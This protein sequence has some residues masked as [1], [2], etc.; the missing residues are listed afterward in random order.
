LI[1]FNH[2]GFIFSKVAKNIYPEEIQYELKELLKNK[3]NLNILD[4]GAGTGALSDFVFKMN[5]DSNFVCVDPAFGMLK[6]A[7][8]YAFKVV[9]K[10]EDLPIKNETIDLILIGE[11]IHHFRD[12]DKSL[13][14]IKRVLKKNGILFIFDFDVSQF[15]G[16]MICF[17]E[18][19]LG[20]PGNFYTPDSLSSLLQ[21]NGFK[22]KIK[23]YGY[24][25]TIT[26]IY[27]K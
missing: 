25:F 11:A 7:P 9:G 13:D 2:L 12:V 14:E 18:K 10:A 22:T 8:E 23:T 24:K 3:K 27:E 16:K 15:K 6:Y 5:S 1:P 21:K 20:E 19:L 17:F 4:I 26:G